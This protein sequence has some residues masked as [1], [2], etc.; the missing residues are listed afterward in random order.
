VSDVTREEF[1]GL[2]QR[3]NNLAADFGACKAAKG[4]QL[5]NISETNAQQTANIEKLFAISSKNNSLLASRPAKI[6]GAMAG[7]LVLLEIANKF[8]ERLGY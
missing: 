7:V 3:M 4:E 6:I 5:K 2:G 1:N 8:L